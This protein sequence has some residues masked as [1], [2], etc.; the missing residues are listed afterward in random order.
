MVRP[1]G[2]TDTRGMEEMVHQLNTLVSGYLTP[3]WLLA[4]G[5]LF[6]AIWSGAA[7]RALLFIQHRVDRA[8]RG[9]GHPAGASE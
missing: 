2:I 7:G 6:T 5:M 8:H 3:A 9:R 1:D 4:L